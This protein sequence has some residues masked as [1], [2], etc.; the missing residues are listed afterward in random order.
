MLS[1]WLVNACGKSAPFNQMNGWLVNAC[2]KSAPFNQM[3][4][5]MAQ[6]EKRRRLSKHH[7]ICRNCIE[8]NMVEM[9]K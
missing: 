1:A 5:I 9:I 7:G 3:N 6:K 8:A 2:G 4:E